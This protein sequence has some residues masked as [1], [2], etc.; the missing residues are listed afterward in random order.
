MGIQPVLAQ[1]S[2][3]QIPS[4]VDSSE[5]AFGTARTLERLIHVPFRA[6][7]E[8]GDIVSR[9]Q[10]L[11]LNNT[12]FELLD[13]ENDVGV[14]GMIAVHQIAVQVHVLIFVDLDRSVVPS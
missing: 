1:S 13:V 9:L 14:A 7:V 11:I 2:I 8:E 5:T 4:A 10:R 6:W 3:V 12:D